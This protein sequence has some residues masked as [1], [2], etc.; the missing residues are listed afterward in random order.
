[1]ASQAEFIDLVKK[2]ESEG[3][4]SSRFKLLKHDVAP[5]SQKEEYCVCS[6]FI[7][8]DRAAKMRG[9]GVHLMILEI[10][11]LTCRHP[12]NPRLAID[13]RYS[14]RHYPDHGDPSLS[15]EAEKLFKGVEF[16]DLR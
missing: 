3:S 13:V 7:A 5:Y 1:V 4:D 8:E 12:K 11:S 15:E 10:V 2:K 14:H 16:T 9:G 6:R